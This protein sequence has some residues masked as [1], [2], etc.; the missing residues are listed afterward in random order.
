MLA[1][2]QAGHACNFT[3]WTVDM[4]AILQAGHA[5]NLQ[6]GHAC[7]LQAPAP[8][9]EPGQNKNGK[10]VPDPN[11]DVSSPPQWPPPGLGIRSFTLR[12]FALVA[13]YQ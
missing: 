12:S 7:N 3:G 4:L 13:P 11:Q 1:I 6:A 8:D 2:L 10:Y 5:C 9:P